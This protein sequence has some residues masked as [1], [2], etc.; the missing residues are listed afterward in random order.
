MS[1]SKPMGGTHANHYFSKDD[2][3]LKDGLKETLW[4][5][6]G[7]QFLGLAGRQVDPKTFEKIAQG[8]D[9]SG[10]RLIHPG[11][12]GKH[13][14]GFDL[15]FSAPKS[16]SILST[17]DGRILKAHQEAVKEALSYLETNYSQARITHGKVTTLIRTRNIT[18]TLFPHFTSRELDPQLHTHG[19]IMNMTLR[20][21]GNWRALDRGSRE[22]AGEIYK[23]QIFLGQIYQKSGVGRN[24][25]TPQGRFTALKNGSWSASMPQRI[26]MS[27]F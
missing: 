5:G 11:P 6:K 16:V 21:D 9:L 23:N 26:C 15:T 7:A 17:V 27:Q 10:N 3:Y 14:A 24:F 12:E 19:F 4:F 1:I 18:A 13:T 22:E 8:L 25:P 20:P 2:Y